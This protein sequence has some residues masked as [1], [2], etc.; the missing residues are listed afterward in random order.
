MDSNLN[1]RFYLK[2]WRRFDWLVLGALALL[3]RLLVLLTL[4]APPANDELEYLDLANSLVH[5]QGF[6]YSKQF[7]WNESFRSPLYPA[8]LSCFILIQDEPVRIIRLFQVFLGTVTVTLAYVLA[9]RITGKRFPALIAG[10]L[11]A[12]HPLGV[13]LSSKILTETVFSFLVLAFLFSAIYWSHQPKYRFAIVAGICLGLAILCRSNLLPLVLALPIAILSP[14]NATFPVLKLRLVG[15]G[16][17]VL[18]TVLIL[19]PWCI[20]NSLTYGHPMLVT[21]GG[22]HLFWKGNSPVTWDLLKGN[23]EE[24]AREFQTMLAQHGTPNNPIDVDKVSYR[25]GFSYWADSPLEAIALKVEMFLQMWKVWPSFNSRNDIVVGHGSDTKLINLR[26]AKV[27]WY[28]IFDLAMGLGIIGLFSKDILTVRIIA[29]FLLTAIAVSV[30]F[31][32]E[33]RHRYPFDLVLFQ[34]TAM[35]VSYFSWPAVR[36]FVLK[37]RPA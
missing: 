16:I 14:P 1:E 4:S 33:P 35:G 36:G 22:G 21:N 2:K 23:A 7:L 5:G 37:L 3:L 31:Y 15:V 6:Q 27:A 19:A 11:S 30:I 25:Q 13:T 20:R 9:S 12:I 28:L 17:M 32:C 29:S 10:F 8:I 26:L 34:L 24:P 18:T